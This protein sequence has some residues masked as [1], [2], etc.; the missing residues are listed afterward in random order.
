MN[1]SEYLRILEDLEVD[2]NHLT[3][4]RPVNNGRVLRMRNGGIVEGVYFNRNRAGTIHFTINPTSSVLVDWSLWN[5]LPD[6]QV[7]WK[8]HGKPNI[9]PDPGMESRA[10]TQLLASVGVL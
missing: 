7:K 3:A 5:A 1:L 10:L 6:K 8:D 2:V 9:V 4:K